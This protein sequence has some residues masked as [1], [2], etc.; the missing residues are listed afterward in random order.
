MNRISPKTLLNSKW[1]SIQ[2]NAKEK[3]FV[4]IKVE[5]DENKNVVDCIIEA[6]MTANQYV[7]NWR[8]LKQPTKWKIGWQ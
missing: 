2:V 8:D 4:I 3:H 1:T 7:I 5:F 6:V